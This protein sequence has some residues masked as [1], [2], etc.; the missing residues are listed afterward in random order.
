M[1]PCAIRATSARRLPVHGGRECDR[2]A[3][4]IRWARASAALV[5]V[6][7]VSSVVLLVLSVAVLVSVCSGA[8]LACTGGLSTSLKRGA[9]S[10]TGMFRRPLAALVGV[11]DGFGGTAAARH[12]KAPPLGMVVHLMLVSGDG[13]LKISIRRWYTKMNIRS[14]PQG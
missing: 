5:V 1:H 3:R 7:L 11:F 14:P 9:P 4:G 12:L 2:A 13:T 6:V 10:P 8:S